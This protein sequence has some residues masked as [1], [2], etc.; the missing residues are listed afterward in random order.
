[1]GKKYDRAWK[2]EEG[3]F[4]RRYRNDIFTLFLTDSGCV[5]EAV[6]M[7]EAIENA[8]AK[9]QPRKKTRPAGNLP[10]LQGR[11]LK[12]TDQIYKP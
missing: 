4:T 6:M 3:I 1:M 9:K 8:A 2:K 7:L 12:K 10:G 5:T 11:F